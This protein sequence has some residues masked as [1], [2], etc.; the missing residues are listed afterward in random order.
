MFRRHAGSLR[1]V[2]LDWPAFFRRNDVCRDLSFIALLS[3]GF[4]AAPIP[5]VRGW[6]AYSVVPFVGLRGE[7]RAGAK[8]A[9]ERECLLTDVAVVPLERVCEEEVRRG[10]RRALGHGPGFPEASLAMRVC[11]VRCDGGGVG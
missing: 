2:Q 8:R 6:F 7:A 4:A 1:R 3:A 11:F 10:V 9:L 5:G